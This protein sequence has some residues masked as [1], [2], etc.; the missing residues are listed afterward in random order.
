MSLVIFEILIGIPVGPDVL[1]WAGEGPLTDGLFDLGLAMLVF[2]AGSEI[3]YHA[4]YEI[5]FDEVRATR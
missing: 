5:E 3:E 1:G 4:G 2:V